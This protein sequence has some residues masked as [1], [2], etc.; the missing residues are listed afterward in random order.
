MEKITAENFDN[1]LAKSILD[2]LVESNA[3]QYA[4]SE[5]EGIDS[6]EYKRYQDYNQALWD[7]FRDEVLD[8]LS[9]EEL[10]LFFNYENKRYETYSQRDDVY[11]QNIASASN[12]RR[13]NF[14]RALGKDSTASFRNL[15]QEVDDLAAKTR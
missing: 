3:K 10:T 15:K 2:R 1:S 7:L 6:M 9:K 13:Y 5:V 11:S 12:D 4:I 8:K 14:A